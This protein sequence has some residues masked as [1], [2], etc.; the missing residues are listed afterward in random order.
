MTA[1]AGGIYLSLGLNLNGSQVVNSD[2][3]LT[4]VTL[5]DNVASGV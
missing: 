4:R 1:D 3:S 2:F 5:T